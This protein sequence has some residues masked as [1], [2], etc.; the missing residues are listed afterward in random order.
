MAYQFCY[1]R[2]VEFSET[3]MA[4]I[5]H[6]S[7]FF[8]FMESAESAFYRSLGFSIVHQD[9]GAGWPRVHAECDYAHPLRFEQEVDIHLLVKEKRRRSIAYLFKFVT[10]EA[11]ETLIAARGSVVAVY[12][13]RSPEGE[14]NSAPIPSDFDLQIESAPP[15]KIAQW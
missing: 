15:E 13:T 3:D 11:G 1:R 5:M 4:G 7:N 9:A 2:R 10:Q 6:F 12:V 14:L 8:R